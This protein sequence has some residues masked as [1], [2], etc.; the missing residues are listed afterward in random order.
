MPLRISARPRVFRKKPVS[1]GSGWFE[2]SS[3]R[4]PGK[5]S[6]RQKCFAVLMCDTLMLAFWMW[7]IVF[8]LEGLDSGKQRL[9]LASGLLMAAAAL[10][11]YFGICLVPLLLAW[12]LAKRR[13]LGA[14]AWYSLPVAFLGAYQMWTHA[15]YG[16]AMFSEAVLFAPQRLGRWRWI[17]VDALVSASFVGGCTLSALI[18]APL[19]W[20]RRHLLV[21]V[22]AGVVVV[23]GPWVVSG[24]TS[25]AACPPPGACFVSRRC[26]RSLRIRERS[27]LPL[28]AC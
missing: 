27:P 18:L 19:V 12:S 22:L 26:H 25:A 20:T 1:P 4:S 15:L 24:R 23:A 14:W 3:Q 21:A 16:R 17:L 6:S 7:A 28:I 2:L 8:W 10:S 11:K 13:R 9:L 5:G